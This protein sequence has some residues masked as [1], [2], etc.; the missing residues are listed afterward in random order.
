[1]MMPKKKENPNLSFGKP[2]AFALSRNQAGGDWAAGLLLFR[3][4][5][6][7]QSKKKL[8]RFGKEWIAMSRSDWAREAGLSEGEMKNRALPILRKRPF[9]TIRAM[10]LGNR[11]LLWMSL[12]ETALHEATKSDDL[13]DA[14]LNGS[15]PPGYE[16]PAK[17]YPY[18]YDD[19][20]KAMNGE[21]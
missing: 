12:D 2:G 4:K 6:R 11:K 15:V 17:S 3:L 5:F 20:D 9:V 19:L 16:K 14:L 21:L 1:M 8:E 10:R 18:Q 13:N 7:W